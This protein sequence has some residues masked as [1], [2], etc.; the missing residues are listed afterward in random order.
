MVLI[1]RA[2]EWFSLLKRYEDFTMG[3]LSFKPDSVLYK[4][5]FHIRVFNGTN[6]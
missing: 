3:I 4:F 5:F 6:D 2:L 1:V